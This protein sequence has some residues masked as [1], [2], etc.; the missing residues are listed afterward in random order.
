MNI[1]KIVILL[2]FLLAIVGIMAP[3]NASLESVN[4]ENKVY[5][6]ESKEKTAKYK[7]TWNANG[8]KIG[9]KKTMVTTVKKGSKIS[10][11]PVTPKRSGYTFGGWYTKK[12]GGKKVGVNTKP[13]NIVTYFAQWKKGSAT[14]LNNEEKKL[15]GSWWHSTY[16]YITSSYDWR[17]YIFH[18]DRTFNYIVTGYK[19]LVGNSQSNKTGNYKVANGK[20]TFTNI[21][22]QYNDVK[23]NY[24][25]TVVEYQF[26]KSSG[27]D[28]LKIRSLEFPS[29]NYLDNDV[30][31]VY[32]KS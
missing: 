8:G 3:V 30:S 32:F 2:M 24:P 14:V 25:N 12:D 7:I 9:S 6:I 26:V 15:V 18:N 17:Y 29:E 10:K 4:S 13:S 31:Y 21:V 1:K 27:K 22:Y 23:T 28:S 11:L 5:T 16:N 20:L 19:G